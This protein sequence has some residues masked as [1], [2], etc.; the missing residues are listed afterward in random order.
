MDLSV[1]GIFKIGALAV[2]APVAWSLARAIIRGD[3]QTLTVG[4]DGAKIE[5][6][7]AKRDETRYYR[8]RRIAAVDK[9]LDLEARNVTRE[10]KKPLKRALKSDHLCSAALQ[11]IAS[12]LL[13]QLYDAVNRNDFKH[14]LTLENTDGYREEKL[15]VIRE[16]YEDFVEDA[17]DAPCSDEA[18]PTTYP[19]WDEIEAHVTRTLNVWMGQIRQ[20]VIEACRRKLE[21]YAE[22]APGAKGDEHEVEVIT[23]C[24]K[25]NE[26]YIKALGGEI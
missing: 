12:D 8:D 13:Y 26:G 10:Q 21:V 17:L 22:Y 19:A 6:K 16:E 2:G 5:A 1:D 20:K 15:R 25:K 7:Q 23:G 4:K 18:N 14:N 24:I 3:I 9:W 11:A